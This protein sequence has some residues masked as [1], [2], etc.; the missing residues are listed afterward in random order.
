MNEVYEWN[1]D[2]IHLPSSSKAS[3]MSSTSSSSAIYEWFLGDLRGWR[4]K[5]LDLPSSSSSTIASFPTGSMALLIVAAWSWAACCGSLAPVSAISPSMLGLPMSSMLSATASSAMIDG[6]ASAE[7]GDWETSW[8]AC[9][10]GWAAGV[11][12]SSSSS[13]SV[14]E[15]LWQWVLGILWGLEIYRHH[16][17]GC[18][19]RTIQGSHRRRH[20]RHLWKLQLNQF[21]M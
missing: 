7:T 6:C 4:G 14:W 13:S 9:W 17:Q 2:A 8:V 11:Y 20:R 5:R 10:A 15:I 3:V 16:P 18:H 12:S 21:L 19:R 1:V